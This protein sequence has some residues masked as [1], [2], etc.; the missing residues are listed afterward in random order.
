MT[1]EPPATDWQ[2]GDPIYTPES[3]S[4]MCLR[5]G[6]YWT[7]PAD[8]PCPECGWDNTPPV[9]AMETPFGP[10]S[11]VI[12]INHQPVVWLESPMLVRL[13]DRQWMERYTR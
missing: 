5:C 3:P 6:T 9:V 12:T 4:T 11:P 7:P 8:L 13:A 1:A 10:A 2:P